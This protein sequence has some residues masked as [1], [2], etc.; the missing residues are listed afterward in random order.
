MIPEAYIVGGKRQKVRMSDTTKQVGIVTFGIGAVIV[1]LM[2]L[3]SKACSEENKYKVECV[4]VGH[5][6]K[7]CDCLYSNAPCVRD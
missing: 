3:M 7:E 2:M 1:T 5:T 4:K 6:P